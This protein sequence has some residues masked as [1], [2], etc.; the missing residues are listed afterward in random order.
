L[1]VTAQIG[2]PCSNLHVPALQNPGTNIIAVGSVTT[3]P[4]DVG[5]NPDYKG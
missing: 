1:C 2:H 5:L 3:P 4:A